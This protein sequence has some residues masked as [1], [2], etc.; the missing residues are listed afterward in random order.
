MIH[1]TV[2][3]WGVTE[4]GYLQE[5]LQRLQGTPATPEVLQQT[6]RA[7]EDEARA[8]VRDGLLAGYPEFGGA[9]TPMWFGEEADFDE[10]PIATAEPRLLATAQPWLVVGLQIAPRH[11]ETSVVAM[12]PAAL[13]RRQLRT[14]GCYVGEAWRLC[15]S[16]EAMGACLHRFVYTKQSFARKA[17]KSGNAK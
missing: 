5:L 2:V 3:P 7:T 16:C 15:L 10:A 1:V 6:L 4:G 8:M 12:H 14:R 11:R 13:T 17:G 9:L